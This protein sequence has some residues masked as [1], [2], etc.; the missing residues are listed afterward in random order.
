MQTAAG[1]IENIEYMNQFYAD[2]RVWQAAGPKI[3]ARLS[4]EQCLNAAAQS[5]SG[6]WIGQQNY[7][8]HSKGGQAW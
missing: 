3:V 5:S 4:G 8:H 7:P 2:G 6:F 1:R